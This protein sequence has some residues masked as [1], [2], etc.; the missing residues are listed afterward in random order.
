MREALRSLGEAMLIRF[1]R[2]EGR[3][4]LELKRGIERGFLS[5]GPLGKKVALYVH[6]PFC[7]QLCAYCS[8]NRYPLDE[9]LA[10]EYFK[11]LR[12]ELD[13]YIDRGFSFRSVYL[14]GGTPTVMMDELSSFLEYLRLRQPIDEISLETN[15]RDITPENVRLLKDL[16]V[17]RL[18]MGVQSF[19]DRML[20]AMG[21]FS[22]NGLEAIE[23][24]KLAQGVFDTFNID[25]LYNFPTQKPED[26]KEDIRIVKELGVDQVTFY[27]LMPA[28]RKH[29]AIERRF[30]KID[31]G[32]ERVFYRMI[33]DEMMQDGYV[34]STV[35]CFSRGDH[36]IDEYIIEYPEY[37]A[38]GSGSVGLYGGVFY[39]NYFD[40]T[41]Y[42]QRVNSGQF[43]IAMSKRL[44]RKELLHYHL[45]TQFFGMSL[46]RE[47]HR[48]LF[49]RDPEEE[50]GIELLVLRLLGT[51]EATQGGF[52]VT[53]R[54]M[55]VV[56]GMM[57]E[58][59]TGLNRLREYCMSRRI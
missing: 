49:G 24:I 5:K 50:L 30:S 15:P 26:L 41:N 9:E 52:R 34:P 42:L 44:T 16:G 29:K 47:V 25:L 3:K 11:G 6:I 7:R 54:G 20:R 17:R 4:F 10:R 32:R 53:R 13:L 36:M 2:L 57:R 22:H 14:G 23:K 18:S 39:A 19:D 58:F 43:P 28:P 35:W 21:R 51:I 40:L 46:R 1:V 45:L 37:I 12:K 59:F 38:I 55:Y 8:F 48:E 56:S 31:H 27:P 33:L